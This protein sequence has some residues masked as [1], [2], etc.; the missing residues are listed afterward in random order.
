MWSAKKGS[1]VQSQLA[2]IDDGVL[3]VVPGDYGIVCWDAELTETLPLVHW[4]VGGGYSCRVSVDNLKGVGAQQVVHVGGARCR[5]N[6]SEDSEK[7]PR[8]RTTEHLEAERAVLEE[9]A[10]MCDAV[11]E[12]YAP[13][14]KRPLLPATWPEAASR[15]CADNI[16][17]L[18]ASR[19]NR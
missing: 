12:K 15:M 2:I 11:T 4:G 10:K 18:A 14:G 6:P 8:D 7:G 17:A 3:V 9:A 5:H 1:V 13:G 16:R 19:G